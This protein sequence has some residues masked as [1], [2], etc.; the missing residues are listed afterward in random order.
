[1]FLIFL[2]DCSIPFLYALGLFGESFKLNY[3]NLEIGALLFLLASVDSLDSFSDD[4]SD[5]Q[6]EQDPTDDI[7]LRVLPCASDLSPRLRPDY[8]H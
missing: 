7:F 6:V 2:S 1:M 4:A 3:I 5:L 8:V